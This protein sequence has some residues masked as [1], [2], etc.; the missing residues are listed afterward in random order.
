[1]NKKKLLIA[2]IVGAVL[3]I[4]LTALLG[5]WGSIIA[6]FIIGMIIGSK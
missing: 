1:M 6:L 2:F 4:P 3:G 5:F